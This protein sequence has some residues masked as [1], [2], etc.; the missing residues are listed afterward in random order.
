M[1]VDKP[2]KRFFALYF[3]RATLFYQALK[4]IMSHVCY[5]MLCHY[6]VETK[7]CQT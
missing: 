7:H 6:L 2:T 4:F 5:G 3:A 1:K